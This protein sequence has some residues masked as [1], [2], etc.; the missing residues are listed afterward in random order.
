MNHKR[1][2]LERAVT[3]KLTLL[4]FLSNP[5]ILHHTIPYLP[6]ASVLSLSAT[7]KAFHD[8]INHT[9]RVFRHLDLSEVK[10]A[11]FDVKPIDRGG[12]TW[13]NVQLDENLTEDE[14]SFPNPSPLPVPLPPLLLSSISSSLRRK[15]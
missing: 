13:R 10:S 11:Q 8:L 14:L 7:S 5:L 2:P 6:V 4:H 3:E 15:E 12:E 9:P 1:D